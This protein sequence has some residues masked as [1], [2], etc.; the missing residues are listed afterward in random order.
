[1]AKPK[2]S[3]MDQLRDVHLDALQEICNIGMGH[4]ATALSQMIGKTVNLNV[5]KVTL[6]GLDQVPDI[7]GGAEQVVVGIYLQVW[8]DFRGNLLLI[9]P[10]DS[11][12]NL[13]ALLTG[14]PATSELILSEIHASALK[15]VA[16][17]L[18]GAYLGAMGNLLGLSLLPSV[19]SLAFDMAGAI[20]DYILI[21]LGQESDLT[22]VVETQFFGMGSTIRGHFFLLPDPNSLK[23]ILEASR[24]EPLIRSGRD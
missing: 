12:Q 13:N 24:V 22:L 7:I 23:L 2:L 10:R 6:A 11:A 8:G 9:F 16:N 4:A 20:V 14:Q 1:M 3:I 19:P 15:E 5:P 21:E 18:A 17:I